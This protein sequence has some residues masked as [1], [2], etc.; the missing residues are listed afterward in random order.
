MSAK[1]CSPDNSAMEGFFGRMKNEMFYGRDW[2][3]VT[4]EEF[5]DLIGKYIERD[6]TKRIKRSLGG[7]SPMDYRKSLGLAA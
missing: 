2:S 5:V 3:G 6:N 7:M 1:G 4:I